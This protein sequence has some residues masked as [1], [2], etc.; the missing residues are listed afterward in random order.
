[1]PLPC[2]TLVP[3]QQHP[4]SMSDFR[5][6]ACCNILYK[7]V[8]KML[9]DRLRKILPN[10][11]SPFQSAFVPKLLIGDNILLAQALCKNYHLNSGQPRCMF[12]ID[13]KKS[14][15]TLNW[16][17]LANLLEKMGFSNISINWVM[18]SEFHQSL[19]DFCENKRVT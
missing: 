1:M 4:S 7:C 10:L 5:P 11:V 6:I 16:S 8:T 18:S 9:A 13:I 19:H 15:D 17:F 14:F 12:K 2:I 3:K